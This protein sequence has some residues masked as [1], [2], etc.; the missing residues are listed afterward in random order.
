MVVEVRA[1]VEVGVEV[2]VVEQWHWTAAGL[3]GLRR[4]QAGVQKEQ[5][6]AGGGI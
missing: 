3:G 5:V 2:E 6:A 1:E 4:V